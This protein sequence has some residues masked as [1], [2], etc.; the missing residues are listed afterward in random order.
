M[1]IIGISGKMNSG[2]DTVGRIIQYLI[3]RKND[4]RSIKIQTAEFLGLTSQNWMAI[5]QAQ[6]WEIKKFADKLKDIV[7]ILLSCT[8]EQLENREF[9]EKELGEEW[10][11]YELSW[12]EHVKLDGVYNTYEEACEE[13]RN[14]GGSSFDEKDA[15][16]TI[17]LTPR[18]ILQLLGTDYG[19]DIIHPNLWVNALM[20]DYEKLCDIHKEGNRTKCMCYRESDDSTLCETEKP[21]WVITDLRFT[22]ELKAV[23]DR[24]GITI[25]VNRPKDTHTNYKE[26]ESETSLDSSKFDYTIDNNS[27]I[28]SLIEKVKV[29]LTKEKII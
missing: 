7:C 2:K 15:I 6:D 20:A 17:K 27:D 19:R 26:H 13:L 9:K 10:W 5:Y 3:A 28:D 14:F 12:Y 1:A 23:K 11:K 25:R 24:G 22:N 18:K 4:N 21:N 29:I 16:T 8:R